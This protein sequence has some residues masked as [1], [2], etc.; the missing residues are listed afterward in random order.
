M[1]RNWEPK[2]MKSRI[3]LV[4]K[5][6]VVAGIVLLMTGLAKA[7]L[8]LMDNF[9]S[10]TVSVANRLRLNNFD[11]DWVKFG[12]TSL[13][14]VSSGE[15]TNAGTT[16]DRDSEGGLLR[17]FTVGTQPEAYDQLTFSFDYDLGT[18]ATLYFHAVGLHSGTA[19]TGS[20]QLHNTGV[21]NGTIQSQYDGFPTANQGD[22]IGVNI[23]DGSLAPHGTAGTS[24]TGALTG[25][26]TFS[27]TYNIASY[28]GIDDINDFQYLTM[29]WAASITD[30]ANGSIAIDNFELNANVVP[31]PYSFVLLGGAFACFVA[32]R[33]RRRTKVAA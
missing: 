11:E 33:S 32:Q 1:P 27:Q 26:G 30:T 22:F 15:L 13:W 25:S 20:T 28:A 7:D 10:N 12:N 31:E 17:L 6:V 16:T 24:I 9:S 3:L 14:T 8:I 29:G 18:G 23:K 19:G 4:P 2:T 21:T 5:I